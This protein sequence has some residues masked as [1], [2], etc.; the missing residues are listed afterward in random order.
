M[1]EHAGVRVHETA[2]V[3]PEA[4]IG[5]GTYVWHHVQI[6]EGARLG[7]Q[8]IVGKGV[9]IDFDV[10][11]GNRCKLQN[12]VYVYHPAVIGDGVFLGPGVIITNDKVPRAVTAD[13]RL[14]EAADWHP[15]AVQIGQG[16]SVGAGSIILPGVTVGKWA[17]IGAGSV[18]T[19]DVPDQGLV[20]G[21][22]A[23]LGGYVCVCGQR[24]TRAQGDSHQCVECGRNYRIKEALFDT[25]F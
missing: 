13:G 7:D 11:I 9:Y 1:V 21:N 4:N 2:D 14:K 15:S 23:R 19:R 17:M 22:P 6:R 10:A 18:V 12:G 25:N 24:L 16:A 5:E 3:S 20:F 8:C